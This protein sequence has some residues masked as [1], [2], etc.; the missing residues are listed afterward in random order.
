MFSILKKH[1]LQTIKIV[2]A[3]LPWIIS[4][5]TLYL[6]DSNGTWT[7]ETAHR[8]KMSV[9]IIAHWDDF[10]VSDPFLLFKNYEKIIKG[11][12]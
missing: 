4:L 5:Y 9:G 3:F 7:S 1:T 8:G 10:I 11:N 12:E 2:I 6:M